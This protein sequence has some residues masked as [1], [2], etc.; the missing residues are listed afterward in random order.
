MKIYIIN[1]KTEGL[2]TIKD[3]KKV[4]KPESAEWIVIENN[5]GKRFRM[6]K[7]DLIK[8]MTQPSAIGAAKKAGG[9][10]GTRRE[11]MDVG[12][13]RFE[14]LDEAISLIGGDSLDYKW[15][16]T[17]EKHQRNANYGWLFSGTSGNLNNYGRVNTYHARVFHAFF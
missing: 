4:E 12:D 16:W 15:Y 7:K 1:P 9:R 10:L 14:G 13:A 3:W 8:Q 5:D 11:W 17:E 2:E 6:H